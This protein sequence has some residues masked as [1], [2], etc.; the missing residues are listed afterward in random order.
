METTPKLD[1]PLLV[2]TP[3]NYAFAFAVNCCVCGFHPNYYFDFM[4]K[5]LFCMKTC[6]KPFFT[7][8]RAC[9]GDQR[10]YSQPVTG[11]E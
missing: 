8:Q 9:C 2:G 7:G 11:W 1:S 10:P 6:L 3:M 5:L 4:L